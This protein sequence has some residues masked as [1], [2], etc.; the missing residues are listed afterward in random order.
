MFEL[1]Q[2]SFLKVARD[3]AENKISF[4][5]VMKKLLWELLMDYTPLVSLAVSFE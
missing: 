4:L 2:R 1:F 3:G 5:A